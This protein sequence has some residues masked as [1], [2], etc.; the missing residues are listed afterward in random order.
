MPFSIPLE[1]TEKDGLGNADAI[2]DR[3]AG[4][5]SITPLFILKSIGTPK[6]G[7]RYTLPFQ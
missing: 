6:S 5:V 3:L 1:D 2:V 4:V 7:H